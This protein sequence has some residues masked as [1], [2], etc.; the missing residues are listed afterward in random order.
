MGSI[1]YNIYIGVNMISNDEKIEIIIERLNTLDFIEKSF[2]FHA[3]EFNNKYFLEE[4]LKSATFSPIEAIK[5][6]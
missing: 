1:S 2:I 3:E 4:E 5:N 6:E